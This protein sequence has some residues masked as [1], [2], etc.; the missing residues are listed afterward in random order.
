MSYGDITTAYRCDDRDGC[1]D[2][3][4]HWTAI[5]YFLQPW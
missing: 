1:K 5:G 2:K 3:F 4:S